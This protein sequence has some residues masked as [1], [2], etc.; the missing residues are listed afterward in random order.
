VTGL[1][2]NVLVRYLVQDDA[3]Q[4]AKATTCIESFTPEQRGFLSLTALVELSWVLT[5]CY[6]I[7][8]DGIL[9]IFETL[10]RTRSLTVEQSKT[11]WSAMRMFRSCRA[12][13]ED[14]LILCSGHAAGCDE[15]ITFDSV[16]GKMAGMRLLR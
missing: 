4:S 15:T 9:R 5:S 11:V 14:C 6:A 8:K 16:A 10:L 2:T 13:F 12:D 3:V 7:D 1:D